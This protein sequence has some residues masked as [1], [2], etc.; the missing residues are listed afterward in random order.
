MAAVVVAAIA[1]LVVVLSV[2]L[3]PAQP[4]ASGRVVSGHPLYQQPAPE[5]DLVA[6]DGRR[7]RL[8]DLRGRPVLVNFWASWCLPCRDEF[9][10]MAEAYERHRAAGLE[11]LGLIHDD[12]ADPARAFAERMGATWPMLMDADDVAWDA[13]AGAVMPTSFFVDAEGIV[14]AFSIGGF[15]EAG[16]EAQLRTILPPGPSVA[17][18]ASAARGDAEVTAAPGDPTGLPRPSDRP[19]A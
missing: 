10:L 1:L 12:G 5:I 6:L 11:I 8:S 13:Y 7:V 18:T 14:Q 4:S 16:L 3:A 9:P 17:P 19:P 15:V 2:P